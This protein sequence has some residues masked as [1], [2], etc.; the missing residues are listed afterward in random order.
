MKF[1]RNYLFAGA[2]IIISLLMFM[3]SGGKQE[4]IKVDVRYNGRRADN[5][6]LKAADIEKP[7]DVYY[8]WAD[9]KLYTIVLFAPSHNIVNWLVINVP[10]NRVSR[11]NTIVKYD[12]PKNRRYNYIFAVFEQREFLR[13]KRLGRRERY[14]WRLSDFQ[15]KYGLRPLGYM[16]LSHG[17]S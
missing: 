9:G 16:K 15:R 10:E 3:T 11:G 12:A 6:R 2:I 17:T 5:S 8:N 14:G 13:L 1:Q 7:P 4:K